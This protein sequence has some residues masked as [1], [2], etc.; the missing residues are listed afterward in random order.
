MAWLYQARSDTKAIQIGNEEFGHTLAIG[1]NWVKIR[2]GMRLACPAIQTFDG[3]LPV[4]LAFGMTQGTAAMFK[5]PN[6]AEFLGLILGNSTSSTFT[7]SASPGPNL[8]NSRPN[9]ASKVGAVMTTHTAFSANF[10]LSALN[11]VRAM[12]FVDLTK[13]AGS[14]WTISAWMP[15]TT[16]QATTD[17]TYAQWMQA[18]ENNTT[19]SANVNLINTNTVTHTGAGLLDTIYFSWNKSTPPITIFEIGAVRV[20]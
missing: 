8:A 4:G 3:N 17:N 10:F 6:C 5:S 16:T 1:T 2:L 11:T 7:Y 18:M 9:F 12:A 15:G 20:Q 14:S 13:V 19:P